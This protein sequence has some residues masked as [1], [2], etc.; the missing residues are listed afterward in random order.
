MI[1][2]VSLS[3]KSEPERAE[4]KIKSLKNKVLNSILI[5]DEKISY[6]L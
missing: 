3:D 2:P 6:P 1:S 4:V 5:H